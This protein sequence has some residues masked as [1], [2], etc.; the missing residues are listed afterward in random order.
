[1]NLYLYS[2]HQG[3]LLLPTLLRLPSAT[4]FRRGRYLLEACVSPG[5]SCP[6]FSMVSLDR[7][8]V[9]VAN[10]LR[11]LSDTQLSGNLCVSKD[12]TNLFM[13]RPKSLLEASKFWP[14]AETTVWVL[15]VRARLPSASYFRRGRRLLEA[16]VSPGW[17]CPIFSMVSLDRGTVQVAN[18][19]RWLSDTQLSGNL[20]ISKTKKETKIMKVR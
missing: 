20:C 13:L 8:T 9:Q 3:C 16:C 11:W 14:L 1:M 6:I 5:W 19:L 2:I 4:Y 10:S 15:A 12:Q 17:S 7:G 18:S